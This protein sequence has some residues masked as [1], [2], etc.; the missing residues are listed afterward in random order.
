[1]SKDLINQI[2]SILEFLE[3]NPNTIE[4]FQKDQYFQDLK[5][6]VV[7]GPESWYGQ[8][9]A[10]EKPINSET[11]Q[12]KYV[13]T[14]RIHSSHGF[15]KITGKAGD[16]YEMNIKDGDVFKK[17]FIHKD[18]IEASTRPIINQEQAG[19]LKEYLKAPQKPEEVD[20]SSWNNRYRQMM[21]LLHTG[22][23]NDSAKVWKDLYNKQKSGSDLSFGE[24]KILQQAH[25]NID[26]ELEAATGK[27]LDLKD[28]E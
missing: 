24:R 3:K 8:Q 14:S 5:K 6:S 15:G 2:K 12:D 11:N 16:N 13:G 10:I 21:D 25:N 23:I 26:Q 20:Y 28:F 4:K 18:R 9:K 19:K 27:G 1:M 7:R 22:N 17:I